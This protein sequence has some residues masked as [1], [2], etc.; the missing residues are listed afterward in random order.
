MSR[1]VLR[2]IIVVVAAY[3]L[4]LQPVIG[5]AFFQ[6]D[7]DSAVLCSGS[8]HH[9]PVTGSCPDIACCARN[10]ADLLLAPPA[11]TFRLVVLPGTRTSDVHQTV[12]LAPLRYRRP[13]SRAPPMLQIL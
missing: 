3:A 2:R 4:A 1:V 8:G 6:A 13:L 7:V 5:T 9:A 10:C 11:S 12:Q